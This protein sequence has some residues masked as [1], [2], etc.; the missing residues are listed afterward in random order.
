MSYYGLV[1]TLDLAAKSLRSKTPIYDIPLYKH[2]Q[3][4]TNYVDLITDFIKTNK[5]THVL[6]WFINIPTEQF[7]LIKDTTGVQYIYFNWDEPYNWTDCDIINKMNYIDYAFVSC[8]ETLDIYSA[9]GVDATTLYAGFDQK[10]NYM[11]KDIDICD[12]NKYSC[13][14]SICCTNL[15]E[16]D[17]VYPNQYINRK[18]LIDAVYEGQ[19]VNNYIFHIYGP[20]NLALLY[21]NS[22]KGYAKYCELNKIFNYSKINLCTHVLCNKFGYLN[23]RIILIGASGGLALVDLVKGIDTIFEPN[24]HVLILNKDSYIEQIVNILDNYENYLDMRREF[25]ILCNTRYNYAVW[26]ETIMNKIEQ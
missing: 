19:F 6:W 20:A 24:K 18:T 17:A 15:Y 22:Y 5:I 1:E 7:K 25:N 3:E 2:K 16:D 10:V 12:Y 13:D 11:I 8:I 14:I 26:A 23:E 9:N 4:G 21:P